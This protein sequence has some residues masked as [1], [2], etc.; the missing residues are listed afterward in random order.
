MWV[1]GKNFRSRIDEASGVLAG[2]AIVLALL[3]AGLRHEGKSDLLSET[4]KSPELRKSQLIGDTELRR[5]SEKSPYADRAMTPSFQGALAAHE[6]RASQSITRSCCGTVSLDLFRFLIVQLGKALSGVSLCPQQL[7]KLRLDGL[8]IAMLGALNE[9]GHAQRD[10]RDSAVEI[11]RVAVENGPQYHVSDDE[12]EGGRP[13][14]PCACRCQYSLK[15]LLHLESPTNNPRCRLIS[16]G[17]R[18]SLVPGV[19]AEPASGDLDHNTFVRSK[20]MAT[21]Y[22]Q[23]ASIEQGGNDDLACFKLFDAAGFVA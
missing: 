6:G 5:I 3:V 2:L 11:E 19:T 22:R 10:D 17:C 9:Q 7:V 13:R 15:C 1:E 23:P 18:H 20:Q 4:R 8:G 12:P 16:N 14:H 21:A